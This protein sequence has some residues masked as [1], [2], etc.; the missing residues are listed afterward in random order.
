M[1]PMTYNIVLQW[2]LNEK[3]EG[4]YYVKYGTGDLKWKK[5]S[6]DSAQMLLAIGCQSLPPFLAGPACTGRMVQVYV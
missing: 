4:S 6:N 2:R 5:T 3:L 1:T